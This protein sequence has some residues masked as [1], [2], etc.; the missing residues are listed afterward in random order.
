[1]CPH[2]KHVH[3]ICAH[4][5]PNEEKDHWISLTWSKGGCDPPEW[6]L[7]TELRSSARAAGPLHCKA[8]PPAPRVPAL[9][10]L[11]V[12]LLLDCL[13]MDPP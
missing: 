10:L 11:F 2:H 3:T 4:P 1:M 12:K 7:G 5:V 6:M 9:Q 13:L 8:P